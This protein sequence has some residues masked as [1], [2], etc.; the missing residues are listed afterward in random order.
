MRPNFVGFSRHIPHV[1]S[2]PVEASTEVEG[3]SAIEGNET[4]SDMS[5][6]WLED[7]S[8]E[9]VSCINQQSFPL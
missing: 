9:E 6:D 7:V 4:V 2:M 3:E 1:V 8:L 5:V